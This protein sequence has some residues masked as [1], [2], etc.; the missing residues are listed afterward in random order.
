MLWG[1]ILVLIG[2]I[3]YVVHAVLFNHYLRK[4]APELLEYKSTSRR[5][6]RILIV[7]SEAGITP[8]WIALIGIPAF[9]LF[10]LGMLIVIVAF[11]SKLWG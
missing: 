10:L 2:V 7:D 1:A 9:P 5:K 11:L 8:Q 4:N 3:C 6:S